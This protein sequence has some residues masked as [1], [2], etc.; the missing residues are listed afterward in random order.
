MLN[1]NNWVKTG[2]YASITDAVLKKSGRTLEEIMNPKT[3]NPRNIEGLPAAA[4][5]I[6]T[7]I[8]NNMPIVIVGDYDADGITSTAILARLI[9]ALGGHPKLIIPR[10]FSNG[11]GL[12]EQIVSDIHNSLLITVDNGISA[13]EQIA[14]AKVQGNQVIVLDHHLP[15][16]TLPA[17][18]VLV[19]PHVSPEKNEYVEYCGAGL[20]Y[21]LSQLMLTPKTI[22][23]K[24]I[25]LRN[26]CVLACIGT[27][28]DVVPMT[29]DNRYI[30]KDGLRSMND[31]R[32]RETLYSGVRALLN[33]V[34]DA[35]Y[36]E[37]TVKFQLAPIINAT[38][39]LY[40]AGSTSV[41][42]VLLTPNMKDA[43]VYAGKMQ[44]INEHRKKLV[45]DWMER[46]H[47]HCEKQQ[48]NRIIA[49]AAKG[50][51]EGI[52]GI[53][54]GKI[55]AEFR[56]PAFVFSNDDKQPGIYKGSGRSYGGFDLSGMLEQILPHC[57]AGGGHAGAAGISVSKEK[58]IPIMRMMNQY[59]VSKGYCVDYSLYYDIEITEEDI[60]GAY[61]E[62]KLLAPFG[63]GV[64]CPVFRINGFT[65]RPN[66]QG[67]LFRLMG[68]K[69]EH[70]KLNGNAVSAVGF[71]M[72]QQ[73]EEQQRPDTVDIIGTISENVWRG[74][75][76]L[77]ISINDFS[78]KE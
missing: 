55:A 24:G 19:D 56:R 28:A 54:A 48:E 29:G 41:L 12:S 21:K 51:P 32:E 59:M 18:D 1:K 14:Q 50:I 11:Y 17:A 39:R 73:F 46:I 69:Q 71:D 37:E 3:A 27:I 9:T 78:R 60:P 30:I 42:K 15:M 64:E 8:E 61:N 13:V 25:L 38:G 35:P 52:V 6:E 68:S 4:S 66:R 20:A 77:Q 47:P 45:S 5:A 33:L 23:H 40:D 43:L 75:V 7:A 58:L 49:I 34:G 63:E 72:A 44:N 53:I 70:L 26:L 76:S 74:K 16:D 31:V 36:T 2:E 62:M 67:E 22:P 10:R 57:V 65:C